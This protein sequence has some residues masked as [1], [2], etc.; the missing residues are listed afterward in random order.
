ML[1]FHSVVLS[2]RSCDLLMDQGAGVERPI[3]AG[4]HKIPPVSAMIGG[5]KITNAL[6]IFISYNN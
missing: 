4:H 1:Q 3:A 5:R 2:E 6:F